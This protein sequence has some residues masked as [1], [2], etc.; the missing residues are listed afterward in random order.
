MAY[1]W[2]RQ[3]EAIARR[4][5]AAKIPDREEHAKEIKVEMVINRLIQKI[6]TMNLTLVQEADIV[7]QQCAC[8]QRASRASVRALEHELASQFRSSLGAC[9]KTWQLRNRDTSHQLT[10]G[11]QGNMK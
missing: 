5:E 8:Q 2:L 10:N 6:I 9:C 1:G 4:G 11:K 3:A 7:L